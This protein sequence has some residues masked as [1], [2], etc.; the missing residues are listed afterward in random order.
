[1]IGIGRPAHNER[2]KYGSRDRLQEDI[3]DTVAYSTN[4]SEIE[5]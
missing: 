4:C 2:Q 3:E 1:V 5:G